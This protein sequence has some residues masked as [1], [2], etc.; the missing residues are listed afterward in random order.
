MKNMKINIWNK[1]WKDIEQFLLEIHLKDKKTNY[2]FNTGEFGMLLFN[3]A[4]MNKIEE[5]FNI[6]NQKFV[7]Y[8]PNKELAKGSQF[9][10]YKLG[11]GIEIKIQHDPNLDKKEDINEITGFPNKSSTLYYEES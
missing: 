4:I 5:S 10:I 11:N 1:D 7:E 6:V 9:T 8:N 3:R 2:I